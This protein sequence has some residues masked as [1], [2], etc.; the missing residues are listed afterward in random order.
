MA[1]LAGCAGTAPGSTRSGAPTTTVTTSTSP[2]SPTPVAAPASAPVA[3]DASP[4]TAVP[5][6]QVEAVRAGGRQVYVLIAGSGEGILVDPAPGA[7][8]P[9]ALIADP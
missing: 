3:A 5:A 4:N 1:A 2:P 7:P 6:D 9:P 8:L